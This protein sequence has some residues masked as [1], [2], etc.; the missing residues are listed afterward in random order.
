MH[1]DEFPD[2][3]CL[4]FESIYLSLVRVSEMVGHEV[5]SWSLRHQVHNNLDQ[6]LLLQGIASVI[7]ALEVSNGEQ[8]FGF[9]VFLLALNHLSHNA[10]PVNSWHDVPQISILQGLNLVNVE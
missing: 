3:L 6:S 4:S 1:V 9:L 8:K 10:H 2:D 5:H 7:K